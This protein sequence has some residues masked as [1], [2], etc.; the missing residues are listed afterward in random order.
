LSSKGL[1]VIDPVRIERFPVNATRNLARPAAFSPHA[2][3]LSIR[4]P[5]PVYCLATSSVTSKRLLCD[6]IRR[7]ATAD[8]RSEE[9]FSAWQP[10]RRATCGS[11]ARR[12]A[13][14][15][16]VPTAFKHDLAQHD[17]HASSTLRVT[18]I[19]WRFP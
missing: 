9:K 3:R 6:E 10:R 2:E 4:P 11:N 5:L 14:D 8:S 16:R 13:L 7:P 17:R 15:K 18:R 12:P 19:K 1:R